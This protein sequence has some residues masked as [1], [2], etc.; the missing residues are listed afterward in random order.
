MVYNYKGTKFELNKEL[1]KRYEEVQMMEINDYMMASIFAHAFP[2]KDISSIPANDL[3][4]AVEDGMRT[5][6]D[7]HDGK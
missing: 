5:A 1:V 6:I 3:T 4:A 7:I 2:D